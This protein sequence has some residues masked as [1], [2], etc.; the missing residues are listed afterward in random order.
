M[1]TQLTSIIW[2]LS[3]PLL[4][5]VSYR[6]IRVILSLYEKNISENKEE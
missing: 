1:N 3:W 5:Y 2:Y 4:I 6:L